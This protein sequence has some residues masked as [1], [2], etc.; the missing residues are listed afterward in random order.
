MLMLTNVSLHNLT[1]NGR[2]PPGRK[3]HEGMYVPESPWLRG[4]AEPLPY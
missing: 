2:S 4:S 3:V 1:P